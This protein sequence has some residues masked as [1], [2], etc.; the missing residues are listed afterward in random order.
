M[1]NQTKKN[2]GE[3]KLLISEMNDGT[4]YRSNRKQKDNKE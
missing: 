1:S 2:K 3:D 4:Y